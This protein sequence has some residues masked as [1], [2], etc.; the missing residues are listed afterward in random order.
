MSTPKKLFQ[1]TKSEANEELALHIAL[2]CVRNTII[3]NY[4]AAGKISDPEMMAFNKEV[5]NK[6]YSFLELVF[7][8]DLKQESDIGFRGVQGVTP[9]LYRPEGWDMPAFDTGLKNAIE[10]QWEWEQ[11]DKS[12]RQ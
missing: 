9:L 7:N 2:H 4:H 1:Y 11:T 12:N 3:E 8:P 5:V 6:I 10:R